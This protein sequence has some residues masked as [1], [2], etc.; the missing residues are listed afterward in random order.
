MRSCD[1][2]RRCSVRGSPLDSRSEH[3][4]HCWVRR[5]DHRVVSGPGAPVT[6]SPAEQG[7]P[8][9][10]HSGSRPCIHLCVAHA[11][12]VVAR[13]P[14][15]PRLLPQLWP[16]LAV[17][18]A[19]SEFYCIA[20]LFTSSPGHCQPPFATNE[21]LRPPCLCWA[22]SSSTLRITSPG[23]P[24]ALTKSAPRSAIRSTTSALSRMQVTTA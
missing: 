17:D 2:L 11:Q 24:P 12:G 23:A 13:Q 22:C 10:K 3:A 14:P 1:W 8:S 7:S 6:A 21:P 16:T 15:T 18:S 4:R 20:M 19:S 5:P 9:I